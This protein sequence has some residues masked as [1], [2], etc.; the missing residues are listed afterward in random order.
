V[1]I[2]AHIKD[3]NIMWIGKKDITVLGISNSAS[4][5]YHASQLK[6]CKQH[7]KI[8]LKWLMVNGLYYLPISLLAP[9]KHGDSNSDNDAIPV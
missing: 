1:A 3:M 7:I 8:F 9:S 5:T 4:N 2:K 6:G